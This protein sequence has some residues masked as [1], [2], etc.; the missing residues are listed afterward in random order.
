MKLTHMLFTDWCS[1]P[2]NLQYYLKAILTYDLQ[3]YQ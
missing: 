3:V 2:I 1:I